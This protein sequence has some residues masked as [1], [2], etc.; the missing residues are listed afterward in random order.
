MGP[1]RSGHWYWDRSPGQMFICKQTW[2]NPRGR[3]KM[4]GSLNR[5]VHP[6]VCRQ[7][8]S[9]MAFPK[10]KSY[11]SHDSDFLIEQPGSMLMR[12]FPSL[13][14]SHYI[15]PVIIYPR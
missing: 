10:R 13:L 5:R 15:E 12:F 3:E 2:K 14:A 11:Y 6:D 9:H 1:R 4:Q 7:S 8:P